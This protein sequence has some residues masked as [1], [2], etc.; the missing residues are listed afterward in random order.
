MRNSSLYQ[1]ITLLLGPGLTQK[2]QILPGG[3]IL[4]KIGQTK[5]QRI[6]PGIEY[7]VVLLR[8]SHRIKAKFVFRNRGRQQT[9]IIGIDISPGRLN[10]AFLN[11]QTV[12]NSTPLAPIYILQVNELG[13]YRQRT[14][15]HKPKSQVHSDQYGFSNIHVTVI[16]FSLLTPL[17]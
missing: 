7:I 3:T 10:H 13:K 15:Y 5:G 2:G 8:N 14:E 1:H 16:I 12:C 17:I 4:E 6:Y 9:A 11:S